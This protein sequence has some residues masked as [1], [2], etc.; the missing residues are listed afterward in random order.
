ASALA[1]KSTRFLGEIS[2]SVKSLADI[3]KFPII[4]LPSD[5]TW[6]FV[7]EAVMNLISD[8][9]LEQLRRA[10]EIHTQ[11]TQLVLNENSVQTIAQ[12]LSNLVN[13]PI[14]VE[15]GRF[16]LITSA[17]PTSHDPHNTEAIQQL[18]DE[19]TSKYFQEKL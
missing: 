10:Q 7:I 12:S 6:P 11:L 17:L 5:S 2:D 18:I 1:I 3:K 9:Q 13:D 19:R 8:E 15:D 16:N 4:N 14:V